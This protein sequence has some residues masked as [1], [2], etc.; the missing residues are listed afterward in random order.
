MAQS[1]AQ[2]SIVIDFA[3]PSQYAN[4][5]FDVNDCTSNMYLSSP[6]EDECTS[7]F[8]GMTMKEFEENIHH[9]VS[10]RDLLISLSIDS[11]VAS[12]LSDEIT[13][14]E[15]L[16]YFSEYWFRVFPDDNPV[17]L[18]YN[19]INASI[20]ELLSKPII[21]LERWEFLM[22]YVKGPKLQYH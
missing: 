9:R 1:S 2:Q 14:T 16:K 13:R 20:K 5:Y 11:K 17:S 22:N 4:N 12:I 18:K 3:S 6:F 10:L 15:E 21:Q 7:L 19:K 8:R